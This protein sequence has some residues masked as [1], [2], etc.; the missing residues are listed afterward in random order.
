MYRYLNP[1]EGE[2]TFPDY[3]PVIRKYEQQNRHGHGHSAYI[4]GGFPYDR[5]TKQQPNILVIFLITPKVLTP[6]A[7]HIIH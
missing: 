2:L 6:I 1:I 5:D 4:K 3:S 7:R